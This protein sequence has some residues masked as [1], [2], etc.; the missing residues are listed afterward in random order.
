MNDCLC[1]NT[2]L[3]WVA[4][5]DVLLLARVYEK[6][7]DA[8]EVTDL[9]FDLSACDD[10]SV[11]ATGFR[12]ETLEWAIAQDESNCL[13]VNIPH[14]LTVG[15]WAVEI[16]CTR[17]GYHV[18][19]FE[20]TFRIVETNCEAQTTFEVVDGCQSASVRVALQIV[21]Q[22]FGRGQNSYEMWKELPGNEDKTLQEYIDE[23]LDLNGITSRMSEL[24]VRVELAE[25]G[26]KASETNR[27]EAEAQREANSQAA[28]SA[29]NNAAAGAERVNASLSGTTL[30]VTN[31]S[32]VSTSVDTKGEPGGDGVGVPSGGSTGQVLSKK[33]GT[34]YDTQWV[35][36]PAA[37]VNSVN[38][39]TGDVTLSASDVGAL[40]DD[41]VIPDAVTEQTVSGWGFTKNT[42]TYSKPSGGIPSAD[43]SGDVQTSLGKADTAL[44]SFEETD[45][46]VPSWAKQ[47]SKPSYSYSEIS[48]TPDLSGFITNAVDDLVNYYLKSETYTKAEV[49]GLIDAV[50]QF[51]YQVVS[52]LPTAS[53]DTMH[54]IYLVP[55]SD[56]QT[57]N[58]K[59]EYIT[60]DNGSEAETRYTWEQ[61]GSTAIDLSGYIEKSST[62][63]LVKNDGT[64]DTT[65][66]TTN[67]G[68]ITG[69]TMNG[70]SK[71]TSGVVDLGTVITS[72][73]DISGKADKA[74]TLSGYGITDAKI[75]NGVITLGS[76]TITPLTSFTESDPTVPSWA[77]QSTK[78]SYSYS[79]ITD[80]PTLATV[81]TSGS[82]N[83]L[84]NTPTIPDVTNYV[85]KSQTAGLLKNDGTVDTNTYLTQHQDISGKQDKIDSSH[86]LSADL[87]EDGT[88]NKSYTATEKSKL[89][90]IADGAEVNVQANWNESNSSS[91][92]YIQNKPTIPDAVSG[93]NDG[94]NWTSLTI[95]ST[96]K[97]IPSGGGSLPSNT[98][99]LSN[100]SGGGIVPD[101]GVRAVTVT[102]AATMTISPDVVTVIDGFVGTAAIT[103]QV[104]QD[105]L[106]HVWDILMTTGSSVAITFAMSNSETILYPDGF[107]LGASTAVEINVIG[108]GTKYYLRYG[109]FA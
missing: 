108:V 39:K 49:Q 92:A 90:G 9:P 79:E 36:P 46:T 64:I 48:N 2:L 96:T 12:T 80:K 1:N 53:A 74:T 21:P 85:Q 23:V 43:L 37:G 27:E 10:I 5:N 22:A 45:P 29:A 6:V 8:G 75:D 18:R 105:N 33:S 31:R 3:S 51:T 106:A 24:E 86:K 44:Q 38:G 95:G 47:S 78:P 14:T 104:P 66:Y 62:A 91:D 20:F 103:L 56:P 89:A 52:T 19:S 57:Q 98:A 72:H 65:Q 93:T 28:V 61:I 94:T 4:G 17:N 76:N 55:S 82:Y 32:G 15:E 25:R 77:K 63:G 26:R 16:K 101:D 60:I 100:D 73:Q 42:G 69:I 67:T 81:A 59:D 83:D 102:S 34:D 70:A 11:T 87:V 58:V 54:I 68:T 84:S 35:N 88:T 7:L 107:A 99:Y 40:S 71:G 109:E 97:A 30:T 50:K 41:T 13:A